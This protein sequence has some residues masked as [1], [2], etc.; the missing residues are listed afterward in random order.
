MLFDNGNFL[1]AP[2]AIDPYQLCTSHLVESR[3]I[4]GKQLSTKLAAI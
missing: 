4:I 2:R 3:A 1:T